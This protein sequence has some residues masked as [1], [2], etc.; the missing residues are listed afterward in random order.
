[1]FI[2]SYENCI[3]TSYFVFCY[4]FIV[5]CCMCEVLRSALCLVLTKLVR[6]LFIFSEYVYQRQSD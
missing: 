6:M 1:M 2:L 4:V 5:F 3:C